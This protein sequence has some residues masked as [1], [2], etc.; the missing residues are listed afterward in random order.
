[1]DT[2]L[3]EIGTEE[4]PARF[5]PKINIQLAE[6]V[7]KKFADKKIPYDTVKVYSTPRRLAFLLTGLAKQQPDNML[8][9]K[10]PALKI[11]KTPEGEYSKAAQGFA[12]SQGVDLADLV[13]KDGYI[14]AVKKLLG[15]NVQD[16]LP[17]LLLEIIQELN[18]PKN[19]R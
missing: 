18:F 5:L 15:Q 14:Y 11:A 2:L 1:M 10:G 19:M 16:L 17:E 12:R 7:A 3:L 6:L 13:E 4:I 8:E 9:A